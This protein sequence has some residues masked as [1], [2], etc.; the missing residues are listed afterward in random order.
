MFFTKDGKNKLLTIICMALLLLMKSEVK[1]EVNGEE[2]WLWPL[3]YDKGITSYHGERDIPVA[4]AS[5]NHKGIDI[6]A[7]EGTPI[8]ATKSGDIVPMGYDRRMGNWTVI[9]HRDGTYSTYQ[10][11]QSHEIIKEGFVNKGDIIGYVGRTGNSTGAHLHFE[12]RIGEVGRAK[13]FYLMPPVNPLSYEYT[14]APPNIIVEKEEPIQR[15]DNKNSMS[16]NIYPYPERIIYRN[17]PMMRGD[18]IKWVQTALCDLGYILVV[19]GFFGDISKTM[20]IQ[21]QR[22]NNLVANGVCDESTLEKLNELTKT[23]EVLI[24]QE[25][26]DVVSETIGVSKP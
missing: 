17:I 12:I 21:F 3:P 13:E 23:N 10:H 9:D 16:K 19:D 18:D 24:S 8:M 20:L 2:L 25:T 22:D 4:G 5:S 14:N 7:I 26:S 6:S 11:M 1:A 15:K